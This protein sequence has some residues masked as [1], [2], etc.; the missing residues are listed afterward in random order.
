MTIIWT[1]PKQKISKYFSVIEVTK[2]DPKRIPTNQAH[3]ANILR[4]A[5][6]LDEIREAWGAPIGVTSWYR[7]IP[8]NRAIG[9]AKNSQHI[10]GSAADIYPIDDEIL[11]FQSW[12][13]KRWDKALGYGAKKGFVHID[14]RP[15]RIRWNY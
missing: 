2:G 6:E 5:K 15:N 10:N 9:G 1:D 13:D 11:P 4:L 12:L 7:P 8:V 14:L 3:I